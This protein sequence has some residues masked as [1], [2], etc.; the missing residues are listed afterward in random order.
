MAKRIETIVDSIISKRSSGSRVSSFNSDASSLV[1]A[2]DIRL[3]IDIDTISIDT[4]SPKQRDQL[5]A[6]E[7][8]LEEIKRRRID[9][10]L[11]ELQKALLD[12]ERVILTDKRGLTNRELVLLGKIDMALD[13][14]GDLNLDETDRRFLY[15][16]IKKR[17][18][19]PTVKMPK[20]LAECKAN[21]FN[22]DITFDEET[23]LLQV[24]DLQNE[25]CDR[26]KQLRQD[27]CIGILTVVLMGLV[28]FWGIAGLIYALAQDMNMFWLIGGIGSGV[29]VLSVMV[30]WDEF[31]GDVQ[32][33]DRAQ[34]FKSDEY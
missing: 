1:S 23:K 25:E 29:I 32:R 33:K 18:R 30:N 14:G 3:S 6:I 17:N 13:D 12:L 28:V 8:L 4:L 19:C 15:N 7:M 22:C 24:A 5:E 20:Q 11:A 16:K 21:N 9:A 10:V 2:N 26:E 34:R 31:M 27:S